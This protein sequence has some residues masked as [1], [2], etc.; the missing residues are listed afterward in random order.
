[1]ERHPAKGWASSLDA[2]ATA[3][4]HQVL[5]VREQDF[6]FGNIDRMIRPVDLVSL[7][8]RDVSCHRLA[9]SFSPQPFCIDAFVMFARDRIMGDGIG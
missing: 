4:A 7:P 6:P 2:V 5:T 1:M 9:N 8:V 3:R